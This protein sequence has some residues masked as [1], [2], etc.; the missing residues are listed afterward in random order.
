MRRRQRSI[1]DLYGRGDLA[2]RVSALYAMGRTYDA[3]WLGTLI[4]ELEAEE[5]EVRFEAAR[6]LGELGRGEAVPELIGRLDDEDRP[7]RLAAVIALGQIGSRSAT[8]ALREHR[9][10]AAGRGMDRG[11]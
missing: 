8:N 6:A 4:D 11:D 5:S 2:D 10:D 1:T 3:R 7:V 9:A